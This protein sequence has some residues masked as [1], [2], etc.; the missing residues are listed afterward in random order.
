MALPV[1]K[2]LLNSSVVHITSDGKEVTTAER[3]G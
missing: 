3:E 2:L 1:V